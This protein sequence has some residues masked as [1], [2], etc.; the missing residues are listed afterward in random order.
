MSSP[1]KEYAVVDSCG[2][3]AYFANESNADF[4]AA[5]LKDVSHLIV[6]AI[7]VYEVCK[8]ALLTQGDAAGQRT[9]EMMTR[10]KVVHLDAAQLL[11][12][13]KI[14]IKHKLHMGDAIIWQTAQVHGATLYTQDAGLSG[15]PNVA[16]K[17]KV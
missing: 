12:A 1:H 3:V 6:P 4:F 9:F 10:A 2:W 7:T 8:R 5:P 13:A 16:Y 14:S 11:E 17:A 15:M